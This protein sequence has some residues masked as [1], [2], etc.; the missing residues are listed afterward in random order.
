MDESNLKFLSYPDYRD[1]VFVLGAGASHPDGVP[2]QKHILPMILHDE[3]IAES[4]IGKS[5][6]NFIKDN[7]KFSS[8]H[9]LYPDL[10]SV[11]GFIDYFIL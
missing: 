6:I 11:F 5:V 4:E 2:L 1:V 3:E 10:E 8:E 7:F 9:N